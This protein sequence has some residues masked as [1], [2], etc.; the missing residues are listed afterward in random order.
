MSLCP[1]GDARQRDA[2]RVDAGGFLAH[3]GARR[4]GDAVH[5]GNV[6]GQQIGE[7]RQKQRRP[8]VAH[9]PFVEEGGRIWRARHTGQD[10]RVDGEVALA[11]A[12]GDDHVHVRQ[13]LGLAL[14]AGAVE[15]KPGRIGA[16]ALPILHLPLIALF[17]DLERRNSPAPADARRKAQTSSCR[18]SAWPSINFCQCASGPSPSV[19][20]MP[21]PV[22]QASRC[23]SA[24]GRR[25][26]LQS[27]RRR[28]FAHPLGHVG[29][30]EIEHA[31]RQRGIAD[32][33]AARS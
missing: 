9:Q 16:D 2:H 21:T 15:R 28:D 22:I 24:I 29:V 1:G 26:G 6:A 7:L 19:E 32:E 33:L 31:Q 13:D 27:D 3:E 25:L 30:G 10:R 14:D 11:A 20:T 12:G 5:D 4:A 8:Q 18:R 17:R 23:A